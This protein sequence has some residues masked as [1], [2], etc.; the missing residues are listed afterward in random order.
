MGK[1][2]NKRETPEQREEKKEKRQEKSLRRILEQKQAR[3]REDLREIPI[4]TNSRNM[5]PTQRDERGQQYK[6]NIGKKQCASCKEE[7]HWVKNC[8]KKKGPPRQPKSCQPTWEMRTTTR[9]DGAQIPSLSL[10]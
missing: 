4:A 2:C 8:P 7:G 5:K 1:V 10:G 9:R 6:P 3:H